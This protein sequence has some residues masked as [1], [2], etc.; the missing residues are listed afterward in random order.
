MSLIETRNAYDVTADT[1][2]VSHARWLR[3]A[4]GEAQCAFE[5]A[6]SALL[7]P[8]MRMLDAACGT[9][10]VARRLLAGVNG[11]V[12]LVLLDTSQRMLNRCSG[13]PAERVLGCMKCLPF[14]DDQFDLLTCAWGIETLAD[15]RPALT[16]FVRVT[17]PGGHV[18][19]VFC[20]DRPTPSLVGRVLRHSIIN[21][22]RGTFLN[23][24]NLRQLAETAGAERVQMLHCTGPAAAMILH[25]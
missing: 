24:Q 19:L 12:D 17:R 11:Q 22:G 15:P 14:D 5:G 25:I 7:R 1:Y 9:G 18:C 13:I 16:E 4:G 23:C 8:G 2:S 21:S 3:F 20:A 10:A 6:V